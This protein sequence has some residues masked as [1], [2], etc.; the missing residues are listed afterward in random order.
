M[1][2]TAMG[3]SSA[4]EQT[5]Q[6]PLDPLTATEISNP[7]PLAAISS[8]YRTPLGGIMTVGVVAL[9]VLII[10][11]IA[12]GNNPT[13]VLTVFGIM[14][15]IESLLIELIYVGLCVGAVRLLLQ[16]PARVWRWLFLLVAIVTPILGIYGSVVPFPTWP[17]NLGIY[18]VIG[19][20]VLSLVWTL[21]NR[22]AFPTRLGK[23]SE[24]H[25]WEDEEVLP[26]AAPAS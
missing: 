14:S 2:T 13:N 18:I 7:A 16:D 19:V 12:T 6:H 15:T 3:G 8:R 21:V 23:A 20:I 22:F 26:E 24:P 25:P 1:A 17:Q 11:T 9:L 5:A 10:T 4:P